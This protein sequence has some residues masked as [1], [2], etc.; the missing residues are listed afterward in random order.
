MRVL[1]PEDS[2]DKAVIRP[3]L[4]HLHEAAT[5]FCPGRVARDCLTDFGDA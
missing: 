5:P 2:I 4:G 3:T 1:A